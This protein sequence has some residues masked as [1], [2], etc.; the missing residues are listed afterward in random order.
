V[1]LIAITRAGASLAAGVAAALPGAEVYI[2]PRW[3][4]LAG[5]AAHP[6]GPTLG[7]EVAR[8]FTTHDGLVFFAAVGVA[9]RLVAPHL[10][11]KAEDPAVVAVDDAGRYAVSVL[12]GHLG[13]ANALAERVGAILGAQAVVTTASEAHGLPALELLGQA[14]GWRV[15]NLPAAKVVSA[16]LVNG[17][18]VGVVQEGGEPDWWPAD[19]P[20]LTRYDAAEALAAAACPALIIT[21]RV[22]PRALA[23]LCRR[24]L[25]LRPRTLVLGVGASTGVSADEIE[26]L[27]RAAVADAGLAWASLRLVAT[28]DRKLAEPGVVAFAARHGVPLCG[29]PAAALAAILVPSPSAVVQRHVGTASVCEAAALLGAGGGTLAAAKRKSARTTVAVARRLASSSCASSD[30]ARDAT[31]DA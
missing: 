16:A 13:G 15:E 25:I 17:E 2:A 24:W 1:A 6:L 31:A 30:A 28:L 18:P 11:G 5:P 4:D 12:S 7:A 26:A 10:R 21:D 29:Y 22:L 3:R 23:G 8:L 20:P 19:A 9:V 14:W 27:A